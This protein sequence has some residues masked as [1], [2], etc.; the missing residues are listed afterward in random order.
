MRRYVIQTGFWIFLVVFVSWAFFGLLRSFVEPI[1]WAVTLAVV[2]HPVYRRLRDRFGGREGLASTLTTLLILFVV[3]LPLTGILAAMVNEGLY[4]YDQAQG[5]QIQQLLQQVQDRLPRL[6]ALLA[7]VGMDPSELQT[8]IQS[9]VG[10]AGE[11]IVGTVGSAVSNVAGLVISFFVMLYLVYF[12]LKDGYRILGKVIEALPLG[13]EHE[14]NLLKRFGSTARATIKGSVVVGAVQGLIG[15]IAFAVLGIHGP[16][17][18]G[19]MMAVASLIPSVGTAL[20]WVPAAVYFFA[21][22]ETVN[23]VVLVVVGGGIISMVD[24][25][26][27]PILVGR[28]TGVPDW[29]VLL[30]S[31]GGIAVFGLSGLVIG[32]V[33]AALFLTVWDQF[34]TEFDYG[35]DMPAAVV[36]TAQGTSPVD[37][38]TASKPKRPSRAD[39]AAWRVAAR[40]LEAASKAETDRLGFSSATT[41]AS[42]S[43]GTA[44]S[45]ASTVAAAASGAVAAGVLPDVAERTA[46]VAEQTT[47]VAAATRTA[48]D[49]AR[50]AAGT[51]EDAAASAEVVEAAEDAAD[52]AQTAADLANDTAAE[53]TSVADEV[54]LSAEFVR[55]KIE[56]SVSP[57]VDLDALAAEVAENTS[58]DDEPLF[59]DEPPPDDPDAAPP[60]RPA[61]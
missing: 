56:G 41:A 22:G 36:A 25:V 4:L 58:E 5:G 26:L 31:F 14:W 55:Q 10:T 1:L 35:E 32:P 30:V 57:E 21:T 28:D 7:R 13:D 9:A 44:R 15:G 3:V 18:W 51:A 17:F 60:T 54:Q 52:A 33:V 2:F 29:I 46:E 11:R 45:S 40:L 43:T 20:I 42:S 19:V 6:E 47:E 50:E 49:A 27:R 16:V 59:D 8:R 48:A 38:G 23:A 12:F 24:N 37:A 34:A 61:V 39:E 53:A